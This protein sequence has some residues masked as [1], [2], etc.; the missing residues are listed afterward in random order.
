[1]D[2]D[3]E[4]FIRKVKSGEIKCEYCEH[5]NK[6]LGWCNIWSVTRWIPCT[7]FQRE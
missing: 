4:E 2:M 5:Y 3:A 6:E 1:M 7:G